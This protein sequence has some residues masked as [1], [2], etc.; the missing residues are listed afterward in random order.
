V[1][2][3]QVGLMIAYSSIMENAESFGVTS[4]KLKFVITF[5]IS[6]EIYPE[7]EHDVA[8]TLN[9]EIPKINCS[10]EPGETTKKGFEITFNPS[11]I[12]EQVGEAYITINDVVVYSIAG[13]PVNDLVSLTKTFKQDGD[14]D[15]YVKLVTAS[16]TVLQSFKVEIK[17]PLNA[18]AII[19]IIVV[20]GVVLGVTI[21]II[22]LR[23]KMRIR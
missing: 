5:K 12:Y 2:K 8:F 23:R 20:V 22:V 7:F 3:N 14:G 13:N 6:D 21:T 11:I 9:N 19:V 10:L 15:Y 1:Y 18:S 4:G 16:G 17:E